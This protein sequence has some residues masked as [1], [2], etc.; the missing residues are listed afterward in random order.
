MAK[1]TYLKKVLGDSAF[2]KISN[3][4]V[5]LI[6]AGGVGSEILKDLV[7]TGYNEI[8]IVDLDTITL[9]NL[10]RQFLFRQADID[11]S[12]AYTVAKAVESFNYQKVKLVPHHGSIMDS[13]QFPLHWWEQ[14]DFVFNALDNV[15]ARRYVSR[16]LFFLRKPSME[17]GTR[18]YNGQAYPIF[19]Y[20]SEC[21]EC[22]KAET[23]KTYAVCTIRSTPSEPVHCITWAKEFLFRQLFD[24]EAE[25]EANDSMK[26]AEAI[27]RDAES[28]EQAENL[29]KEANE[30]AELRQMVHNTEAESGEVMLSVLKKI[31]TVDIERLLRI[32]ALWK[33]RR[34]PQPLDLESLEKGLHALLAADDGGGANESAIIQAETKDWTVLENVYVLYKAG[35]NL[36]ERLTTK[37]EPFVSFDKDDEDAMNFVTAASNLRSNIFHIP[38]KSKFEVKE[39]AGS[40]VPA[41]ATT[42]AMIAGFA[43]AKAGDYFKLDVHDADFREVAGK[44]YATIVVFR[45]N[46][47][48]AS[49]ELGRPNKQCPNDGISSRGIFCVSAKD[50]ANE[51]LGWLIEKLVKKYSFSKEFVSIQVGKSNLVYDGEF[52]EYYETKLNKVPGFRDQEVVLIQDDEDR[53]ENLELYLTV[54]DDVDAETKLPQLKLRPK[55]IEGKSGDQDGDDDDDEDE[56]IIEQG[57]D[58]IADDDDDLVIVSEEEATRHANENDEADLEPKSKKRR[59]Q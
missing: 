20:Y 54:D 6:G 16:T 56:F 48:V 24:D 57:V 3:V 27:A 46:D 14:F 1:D 53:L 36:Q 52:D 12:K 31:F 58:V 34:K 21:Y 13:Q 29:V 49:A 28:A 23:P 43:A 41:I 17:S 7:L 22:R 8:H 37:K 15:E 11:K 10:N 59:V 40:I 33:S 35:A 42:N 55:Q 5:L 2:T 30:L 50:F 38:M 51:T 32:D 44:S 25:A 45:P 18:G 19:P 47:Y 26:D 39:I 4:K 9:S